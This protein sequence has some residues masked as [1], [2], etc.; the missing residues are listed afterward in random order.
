MNKKLFTGLG[1]KKKLCVWSLRTLFYIKV[2]GFEI[3]K[4]V[5][6]IDFSI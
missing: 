5:K 3:L 6:K 1:K 2:V 4:I